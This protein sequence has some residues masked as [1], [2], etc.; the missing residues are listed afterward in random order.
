MSL[1]IPEG[2]KKI[3]EEIRHLSLATLVLYD[4]LL[5]IMIVN[6]RPSNNIACKKREEKQGRTEKGETEGGGANIRKNI[7][8]F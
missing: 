4:K 7:L 2:G 8:F 1:R 6:T 5:Q 3:K